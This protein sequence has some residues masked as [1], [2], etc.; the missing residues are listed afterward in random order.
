MKIS[1][2]FT[3]FKEKGIELT[4]GKD[5]LTSMK[6]FL[7]SSSISENLRE[8]FLRIYG[9]DP[10]TSR[11]YFIPT[12]NDQ[13]ENKFYVCKSM[14]DLALLGF[15]PIW[16]SLKYK[17][18]ELVQKELADAD[19]I[20]VG[21]GNTFY[22]LNIARMT[23]FLDVVTD[24]VKNKGVAYGGI[25]A[26]TVLLSKDISSLN[27]EPY[28]DENT[29]GLTDLSALN[30]IDL[31]SIVHYSD[32]YKEAIESNKSLDETIYTI[33]NGGMIVVEDEK[34]SLF[35]GAKRYE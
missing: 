12:A 11:C 29:I 32:E 19:M 14:D 30:L 25:S 16:Y 27:W 1:D 33:P 24:L 20:W 6:L 5:I 22:L 4:H 13:E 10:H 35:G 3:F 8:D 23:G 21:G 26:G 31:T 18:K 15:N 9:K 2:G 7:T 17:T 28:G 34:V